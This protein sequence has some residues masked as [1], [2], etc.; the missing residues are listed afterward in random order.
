MQQ[1]LTYEADPG[2]VARHCAEDAESHWTGHAA[3]A[4]QES[5]DSKPELKVEIESMGW[6]GMSLA[7]EME[8]VQSV[9]DAYDNNTAFVWQPVDPVLS[10]PAA[11]KLVEVGVRLF[12]LQGQVDGFVDNAVGAFSL[13][14][15]LFTAAIHLGD[16]QAFMQTHILL[17]IRSGAHFVLVLQQPLGPIT[18]TAAF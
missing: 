18:P 17:T 4:M 13:S 7:S 12:F 2:T 15:P 5:A 14:L 6:S 1:P 8:F 16:L 10:K 9:V 11:R 3:E